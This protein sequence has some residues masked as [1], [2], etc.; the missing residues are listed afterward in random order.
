MATAM[1]LAPGEVAI[2][3]YG[4]LLLKSSMERTLGRSY[5]RERFASRLNGWRRTWDSLYPNDRFFYV[6]EG[7]RHYPKNIV[8]L[9]IARS[10]RDVMNGVL[11]VISN[12]DLLGFDERESVYDRVD[13]G[14]QLTDLAVV[15][16]PVWAY[17]GKPAYVLS[18]FA[19]PADT[20]IRKSYIEIVEEGLLEF[21]EAFRTGYRQSTDVPPP[22][23]IVDDRL[24]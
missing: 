3:G 22:E 21:D 15:N 18:Q 8:Y 20:A 2:F 4:S 12:Q 24:E 11:Y 23:N 19:S 9:N 17:V 13:V 14:D 10:P 1:A 16:G 7:T 5:D 6:S